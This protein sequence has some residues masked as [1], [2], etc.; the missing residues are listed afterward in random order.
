M[1]GLDYELNNNDRIKVVTDEM[2]LGPK[3]NLQARTSYAK[4]MILRNKNDW[5]K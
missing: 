4:M 2:S 5:D 3:S 1:V